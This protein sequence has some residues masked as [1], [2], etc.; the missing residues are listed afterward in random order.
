MNSA[1]YGYTA[2]VLGRYVREEGFYTLEDAI[3]RMTALP[4]DA[5]GITDRGRLQEGLAADIVVFDPQTVSDRTTDLQP[6][7]YPAGIEYVLVNGAVTL[8]AEGHTGV[9]GGWVI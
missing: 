2:R 6:I 7:A 8:G 4:A 9:L 1:S 5:M 3:R